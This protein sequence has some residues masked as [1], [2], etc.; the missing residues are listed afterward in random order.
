MSPISPHITH[1][2]WRQLGNE[3][4]IIDVN[5]PE[6]DKNLLKEKSVEIA[7]Q[8]NG[9]LRGTVTVESN[10]PQKEIEILAREQENIKKYIENKKIKKVIYIDNKLLNLVVSEK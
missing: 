9:K 1:A 10:L 5:W 8:I 3:E 2:L 6:A 4:A 7:I